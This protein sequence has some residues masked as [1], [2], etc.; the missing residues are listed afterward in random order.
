MFDVIIIIMRLVLFKRL[1]RPLL[2]LFLVGYIVILHL[3]DEAK[4]SVKP[5]HQVQVLG[6][7]HKKEQVAEQVLVTTTFRMSAAKALKTVVSS[8]SFYAKPP[9]TIWPNRTALESRDRIVN[10]LEYVPPKYN[11]SA[12]P[13]LIVLPNDID[14]VKSARK[15]LKEENCLVQNCEFSSK[16]SD[17]LKADTVVVKSD[18]GVGQYSKM[19]TPNQVWVMYQLESPYHSSSFNQLAKRTNWTATYRRDSVLVAPYE[20]FVPYKDVAYLPDKPPKNYAQNKTKLAAW[21][22]TNCYARNGR[23]QYV[24]E[25]QKHMNV[26]IYGACGQL[27]CPRSSSKCYDMLKTDYKFYLSF[28]N[29]NCKDY[30]TEKLYWNAYQ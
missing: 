24:E 10:Q 2:G 23:S 19:T 13:K 4:K 22:V 17:V 26:D 3:P 20:K 18:F 1:W 15:R 28:E 25:L 30:I 27:S 16:V 21:F 29:S 7:K 12:P 11:A 6:S 9:N 5:L 8:R 14:G